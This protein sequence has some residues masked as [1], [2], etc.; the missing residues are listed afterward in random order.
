[1]DP[2]EYDLSWLLDNGETV[3]DIAN[4][5][6]INLEEIDLAIKQKHFVD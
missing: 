6:Y 5:I 3:Q 1:M 2:G 4:I